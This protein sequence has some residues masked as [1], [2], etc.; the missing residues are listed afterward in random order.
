MESV[1]AG[2]LKM[3]GGI[4]IESLFEDPHE[5]IQFYHMVFWIVRDLNV[6]G[7]AVP[8]PG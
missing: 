1:N 2:D 6:L 8:C 5:A 3:G 7:P 4:Q